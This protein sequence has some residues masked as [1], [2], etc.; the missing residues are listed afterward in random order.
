MSTGNHRRRCGPYADL[1][2]AAGNIRYSTL[3][4]LNSDLAGG[5]RRANFVGKRL[6]RELLRSPDCAC[7][8]AGGSSTTRLLE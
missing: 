7:L 8:S 6:L 2:E 5:P 1:V 3:C 4:G